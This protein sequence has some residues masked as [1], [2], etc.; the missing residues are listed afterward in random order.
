MTALPG[1]ARETV[2]PRHANHGT[3]LSARIPGAEY[4]P[5]FMD[6]SW[7]DEALEHIDMN[8][9]I[10]ASSE[11]GHFLGYKDFKRGIQFYGWKYDYMNRRVANYMEPLPEWLRRI[12]VHLAPHFGR[13]PDQVVVNDY[14]PGVGISH[15][16]DSPS[17][18]PVIASVSLCDAWEMELANGDRKERVMLEPGSALILSGESR[19]D[20]T[21]GIHPRLTEDM[22]RGT[23]KRQRRVSITFRTVVDPKALAA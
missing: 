10:D 6:W 16:A 20:W 17:F 18:G 15:H 23:R 13:N 22:L 7:C 19:S 11:D 5:R 9:W 3:G 12:A 4:L 2:L 14:Q 21:H 1:M 8:P